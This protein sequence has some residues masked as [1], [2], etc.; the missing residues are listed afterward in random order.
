MTRISALGAA[1][2]CS[3][4]LAGHALATEPDGKLS[5][6]AKALSRCATSPIDLVAAERDGVAAGWTPFRDGLVGRVSVWQ[7]DSDDSPPVILTLYD[8]K[9]L[10]SYGSMDDFGLQPGQN[11]MICQAKVL[12]SDEEAFL[13]AFTREMAVAPEES[14]GFTLIGKPDALRLVDQA[15]MQ[16]DIPNIYDIRVLMAKLRPGERVVSLSVGD[17]WDFAPVI[18]TIVEQQGTTR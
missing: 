4:L 7:G 8:R 14:D 2:C 13:A 12:K 6:S 15:E 17:M 1:A 5:A 3:F 16:T 10:E 18:V 11:V 9:A